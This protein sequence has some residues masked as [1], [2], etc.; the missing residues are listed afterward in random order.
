MKSSS[1][2]NQKGTDEVHTL[3]CSSPQIELRQVEQTGRTSYLLETSQARLV[4]FRDGCVSGDASLYSHSLK[5]TDSTS[6]LD[7]T[8]SGKI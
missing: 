7:S 1:E 2:D 4:A 6:K 3:S 5:Q 8:R